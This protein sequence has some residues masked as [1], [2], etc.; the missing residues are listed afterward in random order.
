MVGR[1]P[2]SKRRAL[3][4]RSATVARSVRFFGVWCGGTLAVHY[5]GRLL[6][7]DVRGVSL[8]SVAVHLLLAA[9]LTA[10]ALLFI[11]PR[12]FKNRW[13]PWCCLAASAGAVAG[14]FL[15][16]RVPGAP[17]AFIDAVITANLIWMAVI[18]GV[19][20]SI[21]VKRPVE[22]IPLGI[23]AALADVWSISGGPTAA[24][25][26]S[27]DTYYSGGM[28]GPA[29]W[30]DAILLKA[31]IP[32]SG[33]LMPVCGVADWIIVC[34]LSG[35]AAK[36]HF[37]DNLAGPGLPEMTRRGRT[38]VYLPVAAFGLMAAV[39]AARLLGVFVPAL[40][41][42]GVV[43]LVYMGIRYPEIRRMT[44]RDW[45]LIFASAGIVAAI[46]V[47]RWLVTR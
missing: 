41:V 22:L 2:G 28:K 12:L 45:R 32:G 25:S 5:G 30:V 16:G 6:A 38:G 19:L 1:E 37:N 43:F 24:A 7:G 20:I 36:F 13:G 39:F 35:T 23:V 10:Y 11:M 17:R 31:A 44:P 40:P 34:F 26:K 3:F 18:L 42:I 27:I 47:V 21:P 4:F 33:H 8:V 46:G 14:L 9:W 29:P 15:W